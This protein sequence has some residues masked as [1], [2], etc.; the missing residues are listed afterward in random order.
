MK[1]GIPLADIKVM[2]EEEV[3]EYMLILG[4]MNAA[5]NDAMGK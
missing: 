3:L 1:S 5:Q 2:S 4:E